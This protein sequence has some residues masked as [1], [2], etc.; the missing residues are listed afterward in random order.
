M[1]EVG[2][3]IVYIEFSTFCGFKHSLKVLERIPQ[4]KGEL[5]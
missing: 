3:N 1:E 5:L 4:D 2:K